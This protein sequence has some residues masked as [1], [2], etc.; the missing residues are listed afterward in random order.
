MYFVAMTVGALVFAGL[1]RGIIELADSR[2]ASGQIPKVGTSSEVVD[3]VLV[4][5][6]HS[7]E[8]VAP[9]LAKAEH[10]TERLPSVPAMPREHRTEKLVES[11][12]EYYKIPK[13]RFSNLTNEMLCREAKGLAAA[14]IREQEE[15]SKKVVAEFE[16]YESLV[17]RA[18]SDQQIDLQLAKTR[19]QAHVNVHRAHLS[20]AYA[21]RYFPDARLLIQAMI[22]RLPAGV[23]DQ[24]TI[25]GFSDDVSA[26][27]TASNVATLRSTSETLDKFA[28]A[29]AGNSARK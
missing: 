21:F 7:S 14:M 19:M 27:I 9:A 13:N 12:P 2:Q 11:V 25:L 17:E 3:S 16:D 28:D 29:I 5:S 4:K 22:V 8:V 18:K 26:S 10:L 6:E 15:T 23:A 20:S 1:W 24:G